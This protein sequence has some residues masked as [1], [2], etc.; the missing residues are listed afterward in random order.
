[1]IET[2]IRLTDGR[3]RA[4]DVQQ[5]IRFA[6]VMIETPPQLLPHVEETLARLAAQHRLMIITK[7]DLLD[8]LRKLEHSRLDRF[9]SIVEVVSEKTSDTYQ[10]ILK[11]HGIAPHR[12]LMVGNSLR[13]DILPVMALGAQAVYIPYPTTWIH[14]HVDDLTLTGYHEVEHIGLLPM[15]LQELL[16][17]R[18]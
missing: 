8:Q 13:S 2:A 5:I 6:K 4:K 1:M 16:Q 14:E 17:D 9:F 18:H 12:F 11:K 15:L 10:A 7:G 3:V